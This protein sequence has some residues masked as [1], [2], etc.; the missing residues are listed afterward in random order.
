MLDDKFKKFVSNE[1]KIHGTSKYKNNLDV[2]IEMSPSK[3]L[4]VEELREVFT[5]I[6]CEI[7]KIKEDVEKIENELGEFKESGENNQE[8]LLAKIERWLRTLK[9]RI[10]DNLCGYFRDPFEDEE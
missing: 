1:I 5:G 6:E 10:G 9:D 7:E 8:E 2:I 4:T 3:F